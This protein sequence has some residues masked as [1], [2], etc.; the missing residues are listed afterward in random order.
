[1]SRYVVKAPSGPGLPL[2]WQGERDTLVEARKLG[3]DV[4]RGR[5]YLHGQDV[6]I[7]TESGEL[8]EYAGVG[9]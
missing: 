1:M 9:G 7:E 6:R 3:A 5:G 8:V 2:T 4:S